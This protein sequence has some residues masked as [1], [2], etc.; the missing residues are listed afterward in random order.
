MDY[1]KA[2]ITL[3][4]Q[5]NVTQSTITYYIDTGIIETGYYTAEDQTISLL[6]PS[7]KTGYTFAGRYDNPSFSGDAYFSL[8]NGTCSN[9]VFRAKWEPNQVGP[10]CKNLSDLNIS[11][12][13]IKACNA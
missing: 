2:G 1:T 5:R 9:K 6:I 12:I 4:A 10:L 8:P 13:V 7:I 3:Y 11:G